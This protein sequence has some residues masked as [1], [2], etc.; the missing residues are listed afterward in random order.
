MKRN[1]SFALTLVLFGLFGVQVFS[2]SSDERRARVGA[3]LQGSLDLHSASFTR[4]PEI[5]NCCP[6]FTGGSG[7]G[8]SVG[9]SY[10]TPL[11]SPWSLDVRAGYQHGS[12]DMV[13]RESRLITQIDGTA[14]TAT[15]RHDMSLGVSR[16]SIEPLAIYAITPRL[17]L[18]MGLWGAYQ[19]NGTYSQG[20]ALEAPS[21]AVFDNG[22]KLRNQSEGTLTSLASMNLGLTVGLGTELPLNTDGSLL[23]SPELLFTFAPTN[24]LQNTSWSAAMIRAGVVVSFSPEEEKDEISDMEL[25]EVARTVTITPSETGLPLAVPAVS[26]SGLMESGNLSDRKTVRIEEFASN[27]VRPLLPYVFFDAKSNSLS[28]RYRQLSQEQVETYS[29]ENFYN[30]DAMVTYYQLLNVIGKRMQENP[31]ASISITGCTDSKEAEA[32]EDLGKRRATVVRN[33]LV[34]TWKI[35][36]SRIAL[37]QRAQPTEASNESDADGA[38]ENRRVEIASSDPTILSAVNSNDTMRVFD[39]PGVRFNLAVQHAAQLKSWTLFVSEGDR[40][41]RTF[42]GSGVPP[43]EVDWRIAEQARLIPRGTRKIEYMLVVQDSN[44]TVIPTETGS[45]PVSEVTIED[46]RS[47]GGT[48][49][50]IDRFSLIL[51]GFDKSEVTTEHQATLSSVKRAI[52]PTSSVTI[53]GY[54]DRSGAEDYNRRL[55]EQRARAIATALGTQRAS[56]VGQGEILPLYDNTTPEGRFY[57][58]TVEVI[59]ETPMK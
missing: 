17:G 9:L 25:F 35:A 55:S 59:V 33:Y 14:Q 7:S 49:K 51:F 6:G 19:L 47:G 28:P 5:D 27:R 11:A 40:I 43:Q 4:L 38:A 48:D 20:E 56:V 13:T 57:S 46:K 31:D 41:I 58:R 16:M 2:Q 8:W 18:R 29:L 3:V 45:I 26:Y 24:I 34:D 30:L 22:Q 50:S 42:H 52:T 23:M 12:V 44:G 10:N 54:T 1:S 21:N 37:D 15:I 32:T 39:P 53:T 36:A